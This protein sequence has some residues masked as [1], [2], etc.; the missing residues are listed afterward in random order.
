MGA[1][2][3]QSSFEIDLCTLDKN[4]CLTVTLITRTNNTNKANVRKE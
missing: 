1:I 2:E 3:F 4:I